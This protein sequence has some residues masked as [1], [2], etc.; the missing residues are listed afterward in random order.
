MALAE[1]TWQAGP[2]QLVPDGLSAIGNERTPGRMAEETFASFQTTC[3]SE[4]DNVDLITRLSSSSSATRLITQH[5]VEQLLWLTDAGD[6]VWETIQS[7]DLTHV[8]RHRDRS[9]FGGSAFVKLTGRVA[10]ATAAQVAHCHMHFADRA[11]WDKQMDGFKILHHE[12]GN[13]L[14]YSV[15]HAPPLA[16]RDFLMHHTVFRHESGRGLMFYSRSADDSLYPPTRAVRAKQ[17]VAAHQ[18][19]QDA[20]GRGV[21]FTTTTAMD[22]YI[23][24][25]PRWIMSLLVPSE[26]RRWVHA[27]DRRCKELNRDGIKVPCSPLFLAEPELRSAA[28]VASGLLQEVEVRKDSLKSLATC[29]DSTDSDP[30]GYLDS[31]LASDTAVSLGALRGAES[32]RESSPGGSG[33]GE[34]SPIL[35][36]DAIVTAAPGSFWGCA[37]CRCA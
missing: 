14:L 28:T 7:D 1:E 11:G 35:E 3:E 10:N 25:L 20:D 27:V 6:E 30:V 12:K 9:L 29:D 31:D 18:I 17:Y 26:F 34:T 8:R 19:T 23:P 5:E 36:D 4:E 37:P 15:I 13:D 32:Q 24:F 22:P 16:D 33:L 21:T 2:W